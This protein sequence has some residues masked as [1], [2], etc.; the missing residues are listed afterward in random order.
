M[1]NILKGAEYWDPIL[2]ISILNIFHQ[3]NDKNMEIQEIT[4][5]D[6][7]KEYLSHYRLI[8]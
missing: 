1:C 8:P 6:D 3:S 5:G 2:I 4:Q 7:I